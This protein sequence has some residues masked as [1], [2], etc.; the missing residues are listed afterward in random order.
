[1]EDFLQLAE[2]RY[3]V[4]HFSSKEIES[5]KLDKILRAAQIAPTAANFQPQR[6][7]VLKSDEVLEKA[8]SVT[9]YCFNAPV[10][11]LICYDKDVSWKAVDGHDSGIVDASIATTQMML[12]AWD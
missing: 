11:L 5:E 6:I 2:E 7:F 4:R 9:P 12:E 8:K 1:M 3:S 10:V